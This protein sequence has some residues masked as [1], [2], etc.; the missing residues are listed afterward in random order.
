MEEFVF[1]E[2]SVP[3]KVVARVYG[4]DPAW[5]RAGIIKGWLPIG[6]ATRDGELVKSF[7]NENGA[8]C[9]RRSRPHKIHRT[10]YYINSRLLYDAT[11]YMWKGERE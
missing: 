2:G 4:R 6:F 5:V 1:M 3:I 8:Q 7:S 9:N 11:G 10:N